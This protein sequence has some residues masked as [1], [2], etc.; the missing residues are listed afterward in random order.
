MKVLIL[1]GLPGAGKDAYVKS[2]ADVDGLHVHSHSADDFFTKDGGDYIENFDP[3]KIA[4]A[5]NFCFRN[6]VEVCNAFV[7]RREWCGERVD[8]HDRV[9][10]SNTN[11]QCFK[12]HPY[13]MYATLCGFDIEIVHVQVPG[14]LASDYAK[15]NQ[16]GVSQEVIDIM[17]GQ[18]EEPL[19][20]WPKRRLVDSLREAEPRFGEVT[21]HEQGNG[22]FRHDR[23]IP[24]H[25]D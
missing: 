3:M 14:A 5:H 22:G 21:G 9:V 16:H 7:T 23:I 13:V 11:T 8:R 24:L 15:W 10:V 20:F 1:R 17:L 25:C 4:D 2:L 19:P 12:I 6:F 18:W